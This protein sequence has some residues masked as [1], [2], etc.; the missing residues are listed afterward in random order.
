[1]IKK[2]WSNPEMM[3][4]GLGNTQC[5][6]DLVTED[7]IDSQAKQFQCPHCD[8]KYRTEWGL[9]NHIQNCHPTVPGGDLDGGFDI[10]VTPIS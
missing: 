1:M 10:G 2:N 3:E 9:R 7:G 5:E 6:E 4:L 8:K